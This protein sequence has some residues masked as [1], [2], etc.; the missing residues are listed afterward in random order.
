MGI[1]GCVPFK[2]DCPPNNT[3]FLANLRRMEAINA[4]VCCFREYVRTSEPFAGF[5]L[6]IE[7][8]TQGSTS[9]GCTDRY[10]NLVAQIPNLDCCNG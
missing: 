9:G 3:A 8:Q 10:V 5:N 2:F 1:V 7:R 6:V 4:A